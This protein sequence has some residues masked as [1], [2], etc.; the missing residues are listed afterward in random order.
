MHAL[1]LAR[2][3][4]DSLRGGRGIARQVR[5]GAGVGEWSSPVDSATGIRRN[6]TCFGNRDP[7]L[8][9]TNQSQ[10]WVWLARKVWG[11]KAGWDSMMRLLTLTVTGPV[12][13]VARRSVIVVCGLSSVPGW[14]ISALVTGRVGVST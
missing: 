3:G 12:A 7:K 5:S 9:G 11:P 4:V 6:C 8:I 14:V 1:T 13:G 10:G 2:G